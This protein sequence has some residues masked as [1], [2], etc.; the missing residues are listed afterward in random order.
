[1]QYQGI[2]DLDDADPLNDEA[3]DFTDEDDCGNTRVTHVSLPSEQLFQSKFLLNKKIFWAA[4]TDR[5]D[6]GAHIRR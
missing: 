4:I 5:S 2:A 1:V 6:S 3:V